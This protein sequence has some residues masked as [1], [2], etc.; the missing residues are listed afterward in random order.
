MTKTCREATHTKSRK[1]DVTENVRGSLVIDQ[2]VIVLLIHLIIECNFKLVP[3]PVPQQHPVSSGAFNTA[4]S[5]TTASDTS[6]CEFPIGLASQ[7]PS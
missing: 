4:T 6:D 2:L 1:S 3:V 7:H 5:H